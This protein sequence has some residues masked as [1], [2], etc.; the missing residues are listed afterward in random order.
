VKTT[1]T[2]RFIKKLQMSLEKTRDDLISDI[3]KG[4][5]GSGHYG[6]SGRRG[7]VGGSEP[8]GL[9]VG[10][11]EAEDSETHFKWSGKGQ[12]TRSREPHVQLQIKP[13]KSGKHFEVN[14]AVD[15]RGRLKKGKCTIRVN[16]TSLELDHDEIHSL[17]SKMRYM[18][19]TEDKGVTQIAGKPIVT[20][21]TL[22]VSVGEKNVDIPITEESMKMIESAGRMIRKAGYSFTL[23]TDKEILKAV[24]KIRKG[25]NPITVM[26]GMKMSKAG[27]MA[28]LH[29]LSNLELR[30]TDTPALIDAK[31]KD[32]ASYMSNGGKFYIRQAAKMAKGELDEGNKRFDKLSG[33]QAMK[34]WKRATSLAMT[35]ER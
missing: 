30:K 7:L 5:P 6:H 22:S 27:Q 11:R 2:E 16:G 3:D 13:G 35:A 4:G 29:F 8:G 17:R 26:K 18:K 15:S 33:T 14:G 19:M 23:E 32:K 28:V 1:F 9:A 10:R 34:H 21:G 20:G 25:T 12:M 31:V 24:D